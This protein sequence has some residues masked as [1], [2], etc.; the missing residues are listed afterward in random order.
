VRREQGWAAIRIEGPL[1]FSLSGVL[2]SLLTPL[3]ESNISVFV[4]STFDTDYIM[5]REAVLQKA[6]EALERRGHVF[7]EFAFF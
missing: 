1:D 7:V 2:S 5:V 4:I 3:A 6:K